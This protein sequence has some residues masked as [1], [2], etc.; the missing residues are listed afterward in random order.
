MKASSLALI[1]HFSTVNCQLH[2]TYIYICHIFQVEK[3][4]DLAL[5]LAPFLSFPFLSSFPQFFSFPVLFLDR[6]FLLFST[7]P[8]LLRQ[9]RHKTEA[10]YLHPYPLL[11]CSSSS[12]KHRKIGR[13][14]R[15]ESK[16]GRASSQ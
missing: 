14:E 12:S 3:E 2:H 16:L 8:E 5:L 15:G 4:D 7:T 10:H 6:T 11:K 9:K 13:E 1:S